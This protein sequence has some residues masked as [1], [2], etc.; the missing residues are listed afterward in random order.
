MADGDRVLALKNRR[1]GLLKPP[2]VRAIRRVCGEA[3]LEYI[4]TTIG[5]STP[6]SSLSRPRGS[7]S[8]M[9]AAHWLTVLNVAGATS[10]AF[11]GRR[12]I[13]RTA[14]PV[15]SAR[16]PRSSHDAAVCVGM[17]C[18]SHPSSWSCRAASCQ[19]W[20]GG[21]AHMIQY[22]IRGSSGSAV[23]RQLE[24]R[25]EPA[26]AGPER[27]V[28]GLG[29]ADQRSAV[30]PPG[31]SGEL[32][33]PCAR[34]WSGVRPPPRRGLVERERSQPQHEPGSGG[35]RDPERSCRCRSC[36]RSLL[37]GPAGQ[38][39]PRQLAHG[40]GRSSVRNRSTRGCSPRQDAR[41]GAGHGRD[42]DP[43]PLGPPGRTRRLR[44]SAAGHP[45]EIREGS[46]SLTAA[47]WSAPMAAA[48]A[49]RLRAGVG[50]AGASPRSQRRPERA[51]RAQQTHGLRQTRR[52]RL[53]GAATRQD[54]L[55]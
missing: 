20:T 25:S 27:Q 19:C 29:E 18:R 1:A 11:A 52:P 39:A 22:R 14:W 23:M 5:T 49:R 10:T 16:L 33:V 7:V 30:A 40:C 55:L 53:S 6:S 24:W 38:G 13:V 21:A 34:C 48:L 28:A 50:A 12:G 37:R 44:R 45:A 15:T 51:A 9:P 46:R 26:L 54:G 41:R 31:C 35:P 36:W 43:M 8:L 2:D 17:A 3:A 42:T 4:A 47:S 32:A